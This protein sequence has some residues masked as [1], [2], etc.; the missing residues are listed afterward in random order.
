MM[1]FFRKIKIYKPFEIG[2]TYVTKFQ[3]GEKF[4]ITDIIWLYKT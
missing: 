1:L 4:T 2:K 3:T